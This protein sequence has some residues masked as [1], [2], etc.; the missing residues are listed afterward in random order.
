MHIH[1]LSNPASGGETDVAE[2]ERLLARAGATL[3]APEHAER[4]VVCGGDG[5]IG[6]AAALAAELEVPLAVIPTGTANDFARA[7]ELPD[8]VE[9]AARLAVRGA[10]GPAL[11][12][13]R[14]DGRPFVNVASAGLAAAAAERAASLKGALGPLAY[15]AGGVIAG[16]TESPI[17]C[18]VDG[19]FEGEAW[20]LMIASTGAFGG[21]AQIDAAEP[22]DGWLDLIVIES[23]SR[24]ELARRALQLRQ[25]DPD[26]VRAR[27]D[28]FTV[29][30]APR[31]PFNVDGEVVEAGPVVH[32]TVDHAAYRLVV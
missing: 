8:D 28:S 16:A 5:T 27:A 17:A 1:L 32:F 12:L 19:H 18:T 24:I 21:G 10:P 6:K 20:Q 29:R 3:T 22:G 9:E 23:G 11:E 15:P 30:V 26:G 31:T 7:H 13:A 25:G 2:I 4:I 14:M